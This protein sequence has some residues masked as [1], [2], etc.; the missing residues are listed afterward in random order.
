MHLY[1]SNNVPFVSF[2]GCKTKWKQRTSKKRQH[3]DS[4]D[5]GD[6]AID[7]MLKEMGKSMP[8]QRQDVYRDRP[9]DAGIVHR[10]THSR[11]KRSSNA[12]GTCESSN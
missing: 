7:S 11:K 12:A 5:S 10:A 9:N 4:D 2:S 8:R 1:R 6:D 3:S